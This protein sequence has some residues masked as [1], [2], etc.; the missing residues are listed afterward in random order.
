M[1]CVV[2]FGVFFFNVLYKKEKKNV[3]PRNTA[4]RKI[5]GYVYLSFS[6]KDRSFYVLVFVVFL[7]FRERKR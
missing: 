5:I 3:L 7:F 4:K 1:L 6:A 2:F